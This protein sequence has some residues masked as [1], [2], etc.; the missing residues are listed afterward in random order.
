[1]N[2]DTDEAATTA[3]R[4]RAVLVDRLSDQQLVRTGR[5]QA[6]M[7]AV[8]RHLFVPEVP[9]ETAYADEPVYTKHA[10]GAAT[11]AASQPSIVAM[12]L[13]QL[14]VEPGDRVLEIGAGTGYN[15]ALLAHLVGETGEVT[16]VDLDADVIDRARAGLAAAGYGHVRVILGDGE[17]G[18]EPKVE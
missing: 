12:M 16:T 6:A 5:V 14:E 7:R 15:A 8:P 2:I 18:Y 3:E 4:L 17:F 13:D 9:V 10:E 11:S 1:M